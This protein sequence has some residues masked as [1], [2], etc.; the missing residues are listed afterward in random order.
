MKHKV[1]TPT[2]KRADD[3]ENQSYMPARHDGRITNRSSRRLTPEAP[4]AL[5]GFAL[6]GR[7]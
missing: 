6:Q 5:V 7:R 4:L 2:F 3:A 1:P